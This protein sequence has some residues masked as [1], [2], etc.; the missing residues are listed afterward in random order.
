MI[1]IAVLDLESIFS[2]V[3]FIIYF[4][5][6][7]VSKSPTMTSVIRK[8]AKNIPTKHLNL[9]FANV[10]VFSYF[11]LSSY[12]SPTV[13][14]STSR[15]N[16]G[17]TITHKVFFTFHTDM[18]FEIQITSSIMFCLFHLTTQTNTGPLIR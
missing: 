2:L 12:F 18:I 14:L 15:S 8:C 5:N 11:R 9:P 6:V 13:A 17:N 16:F 10:F 3:L 1:S 7:F 4:H